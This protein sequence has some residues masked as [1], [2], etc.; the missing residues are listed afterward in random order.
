[1]SSHHDG[2]SRSIQ[3][4]NSHAEGFCRNETIPGARPRRSSPGSAGVSMAGP[5]SNPTAV[6]PL[7]PAAS[8]WTP[9]PGSAFDH[10][11]AASGMIS[12]GGGRLARGEVARTSEG[13]RP[14]A[15]PR[16]L[17]V[18]PAPVLPCRDGSAMIDGGETHG[19]G[20]GNAPGTSARRSR[21]TPE[22]GPG[23]RGGGPGGRRDRRLPRGAPAPP[24]PATGRRSPTSRPGAR[25][26]TQD[27]GLPG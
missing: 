27:G 7:A 13:A 18:S 17:H 26:S 11:L 4:V 24:F 12:R 21:P 14:G 1:M 22:Y 20:V 8:R 3:T 16:R 23:R 15:G 2:A 9:A 6:G 25:P 5:A 10:S 19:A